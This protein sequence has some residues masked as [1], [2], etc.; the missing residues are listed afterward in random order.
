MPLLQCDFFAESIG[1]Q[2][3]MNVLLPQ[4]PASGQIGLES[5]T[6]QE[7]YPVLYLLHGLSDDH[8]IW[9]RRT[10]LERYAA[11]KGLIIVMPNGH[12]SMYTDAAKS[13][14]Q[15]ETLIGEEI[16]R[17]VQHWFPVSPKREDTFIGGLS[18]GGYG[19]LKIGL[20]R[21][22]R[23]AA[24]ASLSAVAGT[25]WL[26]NGNTAISADE[27]STIYGD[28]YQLAGTDHDP[29]AL[30]KKV[31]ASDGPH[32]KIFQCC[33]TE[34]FLIEENRSLNAAIQA[35]NIEHEYHEAPGAHNWDF[36]DKWIQTVLEWLPIQK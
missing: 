20:K 7:Q 19:A 15:Y 35:T 25:D 28:N 30:V 1:M 12:R 17:L 6:Q 36:W 16:P 26:M 13:A 27:L 31:A 9:G 22:H 5:S 18:M 32:P 8:S 2:S 21:P 4:P 3:S 11:S 10:S 23:Y 14:G 33:G 24:I 29:V 34:D